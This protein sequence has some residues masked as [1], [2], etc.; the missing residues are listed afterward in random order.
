MIRWRSTGQVPARSSHRLVVDVFTIVNCARA[1]KAVTM[2]KDDKMIFFMWIM[3]FLRETF[4]L[5]R[6]T[7]KMLYCTVWISGFL[8]PLTYRLLIVL[9]MIS[10]SGCRNS[11]EDH[12]RLRRYQVPSNFLSSLLRE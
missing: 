6:T 9:R 10:A 1:K 3:L 12:L 7:G 11:V 8:I 4:Q 2:N 5:C